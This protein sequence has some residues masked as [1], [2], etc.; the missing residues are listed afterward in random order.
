MP[1]SGAIVTWRPSRPFRVGGSATFGAFGAAHAARPTT[2]SVARRPARL[3][4]NVRIAVLPRKPRLVIDLGH[5]KT[6]LRAIRRQAFLLLLQRGHRKVLHVLLLLGHQRGY[7]RSHRAQALVQLR[8]T[9]TELIE[10]S[11]LFLLCARQRGV[12]FACLDES[13]LDLPQRFFSVPQARGERVRELPGQR[14][15][16]PA[17]PLNE[18]ALGGFPDDDEIDV[19]ITQGLDLPIRLAAGAFEQLAHALEALEQIALAR[20]GERDTVALLLGRCK[21]VRDL[22]APALEIHDV[23]FAF[24]RLNHGQPLGERTP[25]VDQHVVE[26]TEA[27][28]PMGKV[29][30]QE[31]QVAI[32][33]ERLLELMR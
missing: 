20:I 17:E 9:P 23:Q 18:L 3:L 30:R 27:F 26:R 11:R 6:R 8:N 32:V 2:A 33:L 4:P 28:L 29:A 7:A 31:L 16:D 22:V 5:G 15:G 24:A 13:V 19:P 25:A 12:A 1:S 10:S 14:A 21:V